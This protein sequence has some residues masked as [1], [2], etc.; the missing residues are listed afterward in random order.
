M[1]SFPSLLVTTTPS[2][3]HMHTHSQYVRRNIKV[4]EEPLKAVTRPLE[5]MY[6]LRELDENVRASTTW[7]RPID[8][9]L[10]LFSQRF[11]AGKNESIN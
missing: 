1:Y 3:S 2:F 9:C 5:Q 6:T 10:P 11:F 4:L 7:D 8:R